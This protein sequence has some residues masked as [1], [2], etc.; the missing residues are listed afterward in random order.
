MNTVQKLR[1][2]LRT[3]PILLFFITFIFCCFHLKTCQCMAPVHPI[4]F[5]TFLRKK[6]SYMKDISS[7]HKRQSDKKKNEVS[8]SISKTSVRAINYQL[9]MFKLYMIRYIFYYCYQEVEML[10][11]VGLRSKNIHVKPYSFWD[12]VCQIERSKHNMR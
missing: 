8:H 6:T 4:S 1:R 5:Q 3:V 11:T 7:D 2:S 9:K 12:D 10:T